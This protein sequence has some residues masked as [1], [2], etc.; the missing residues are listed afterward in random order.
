M[1]VGRPVQGL[2]A[3]IS[4]G[5]RDTLAEQLAERGAFVSEHGPDGLVAIFPGAEPAD[6]AE[7]AQLLSGLHPPMRVGLVHAG[8]QTIES[9][10]FLASARMRDAQ[11]DLS[12]LSLNVM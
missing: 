6:A 3:A 5:F 1:V 11:P 4:T 10:V 9:A 7:V 2:V 8:G 12:Q